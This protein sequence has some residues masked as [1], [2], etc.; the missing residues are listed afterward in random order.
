MVR[1]VNFIQSFSGLS[2]I[3]ETFLRFINSI[4]T[5]ALT[6]LLSDKPT[7]LAEIEPDS[8]TY[9]IVLCI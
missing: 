5:S 2:F 4:S 1:G 3:T 8:L 9:Y 7:D 6:K